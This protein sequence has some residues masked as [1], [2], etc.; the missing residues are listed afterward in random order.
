LF[1]SAIGRIN[2]LE[3]DSERVGYVF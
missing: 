1:L 2:P 3:K